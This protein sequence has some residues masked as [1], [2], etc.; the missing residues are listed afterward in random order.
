[1]KNRP[2]GYSRE[3]LITVPV[4]NGD[5]NV[6]YNALRQE[7]TRSGAVANVAASSSPTTDVWNNQS[8]FKWDGKDPNMTPS[9]AVFFSTFDYGATVDWQLVAGRDFS[10]IISLRIRRR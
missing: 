7:L 6:H 9:F 4:V 8:G 3:G 5:L 1:V 2:I 10:R